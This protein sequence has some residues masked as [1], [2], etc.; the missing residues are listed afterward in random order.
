MVA[1]SRGLA[2]H[3]SAVRAVE[4][5]RTAYENGEY[6]TAKD[7]FR[8]AM[9]GFDAGKARSDGTVDYE[10]SVGL[11]YT[12]ALS[13]MGTE[14]REAVTILSDACLKRQ[15]GETSKAEEWYALGNDEYAA[16]VEA[17]T[18]FPDGRSFG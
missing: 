12:L 1:L 14:R 9:D 3:T 2:K 15:N 10:Y 18:D 4:R 17:C 11:T 13:C 8:T 16:A 6:E 7:R 5:G